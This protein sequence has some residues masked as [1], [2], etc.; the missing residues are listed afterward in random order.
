MTTQASS[1]QMSK[2]PKEYEVAINGVLVDLD[3]PTV[4]YEEL[5]Q[6]A[7]PGHDPQVKFTVTFKHAASEP[8]KGALVEGESINVKE[9]GT[10][11]DVRLTTR[12]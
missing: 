9:N 10:T 6:L 12:S 1:R 3:H 8:N 2:K 11:V 5:G 4:S 7:Y